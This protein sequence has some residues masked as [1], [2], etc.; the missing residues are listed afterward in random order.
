MLSLSRRDAR[1]RE[2]ESIA[3][4]CGALMMVFVV[5]AIIFN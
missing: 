2:A 4:I 1:I 5:A 3:A